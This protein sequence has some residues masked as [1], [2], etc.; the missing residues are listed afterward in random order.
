MLEEAGADYFI[1][2]FSF[3]DIRHDEVLYSAGI[4]A[5]EILRAARERVA[6]VF[7]GR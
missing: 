7:W 5:R 6:Q 1:S 4:F 2:R 3:G